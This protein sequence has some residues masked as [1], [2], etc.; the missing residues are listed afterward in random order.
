[1]KGFMHK[2]KREYETEEIGII[3][4]GKQRPREYEW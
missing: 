2:K 4:E 1:M 3:L